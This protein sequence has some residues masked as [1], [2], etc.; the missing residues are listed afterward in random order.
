MEG[1]RIQFLENRL[2]RICAPGFIAFD[3]ASVAFLPRVT[4]SKPRAEVAALTFARLA[5]ASLTLLRT[6]TKARGVVNVL[7]I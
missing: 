4:S 2:Q 1:K 6:V 5:M 3:P 7:A